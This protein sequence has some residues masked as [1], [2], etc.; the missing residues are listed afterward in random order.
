MALR[1]YI[2]TVIIL[3]SLI[4][5]Y[6]YFTDINVKVASP[7]K[8]LT[9][10]SPSDLEEV[11]GIINVKGTANENYDKVEYRIDLND[12]KVA[13]GVKNWNFNLDVSN[14]E[15]GQHIIYVKANSATKAIRIIVI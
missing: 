10:T 1:G 12:W 6:L 5:G 9:I 2:I 11:S 15:R 8:D 4:I 13:N 14:L 7:V 3:A